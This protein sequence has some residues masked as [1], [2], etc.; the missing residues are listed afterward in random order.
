MH[1]GENQGFG[2]GWGEGVMKCP[3]VLFSS[4]SKAE[5]GLG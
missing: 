1:G 4:F 3:P 2:V 5:A